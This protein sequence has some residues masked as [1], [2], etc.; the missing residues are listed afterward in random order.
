[1][2]R[3]KIGRETEKRERERERE[4]EERFWEFLNK[5]VESFQRKEKVL[6]VKSKMKGRIMGSVTEEFEELRRYENG[7]E[8]WEI[9]NNRNC[10]LAK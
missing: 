8:L 7:D 4:R 5:Y 2:I 10:L 1:M 9:H 6:L 3:L